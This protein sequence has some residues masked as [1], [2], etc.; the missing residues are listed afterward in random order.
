MTEQPYDVPELHAD[1][2]LL[3]P[4]RDTD[5]PA[6]RAMA[7]DESSR[8]WSASLREVRSEADALVWIERRRGP[9]RVD[10]A[11]CDAATG[12]LIGRTSLNGIG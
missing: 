11:I 5:A 10:W 3:R 6:V 12:E 4:W 7:A 1:D 8:A 9:G 2:L